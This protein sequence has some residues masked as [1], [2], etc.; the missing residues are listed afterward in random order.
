MLIQNTLHEFL[1]IQ[2][3]SNFLLGNLIRCLNEPWGFPLAEWQ[4]ETSPTKSGFY[5]IFVG[6]FEYLVPKTPKAVA[7]IMNNPTV[8]QKPPAVRDGLIATLGVGL[9]C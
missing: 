3:D 4:N 2:K 7:A 6:P 1:K 9:V 5:R 8:Y